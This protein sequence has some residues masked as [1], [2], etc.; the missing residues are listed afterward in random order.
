MIAALGVGAAGLGGM[1]GGFV[2]GF[3]SLG[4]LMPVGVAG[5][6]MI[7]SGP[8]MLLAWLKLH[9]RNLGPILD[10][11]GWAVNAK[12]RINVPF[13]ASLTQIAALPPGAQRD[14][15]DPFAEKKRPWKTYLV[16]AGI[17]VLAFSYYEG[18]LNRVL[19]LPL[20]SIS[21]LKSWAPGDVRPAG[22]PLAGGTNAPAVAGAVANATPTAGTNAPAAAKKPAAEQ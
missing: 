14:L 17:I 15:V 3:L 7:I 9:R 20:Q 8:S 12:A 16:L 13:G 18:S 19:P 1:I 22:A 2:S 4:W 10:A 5:M 21:V 6:V 11:N